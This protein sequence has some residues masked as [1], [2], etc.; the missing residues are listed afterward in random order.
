MASTELKYNPETGWFTRG[1]KRAGSLDYTS[2]YRKIMWRKESYKE[3]RLAWYFYHGEWPVG[4]IDHINEVKDDNR[5]CNLRD[6]NQTTNMYNKTKAYKNNP[7]GYLGVAFS[8]N[9]FQARLRVNN[10]LLYLG[11]YTSA[12]EAHQVY[13]E[14][15]DKYITEALDRGP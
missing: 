12:E 10:K 14:M 6:V 4:Q 2:G 13:M 15:K 1:T 7:T 9:K 5:A 8:G 11:T 3:H